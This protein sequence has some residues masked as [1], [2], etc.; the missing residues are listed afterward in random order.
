MSKL[1][2]EMFIRKVSA[3][4]HKPG[5]A[6]HT[7]ELEERAAE[8]E[9]QRKA[10]EEEEK[11]FDEAHGIEPGILYKPMSEINQGLL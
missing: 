9:R 8:K 2:M 5:S 3:L 7:K 10:D 4:G 1:E 11:A 6:E